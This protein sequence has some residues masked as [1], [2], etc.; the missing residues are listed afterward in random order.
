MLENRRFLTDQTALEKGYAG[1]H[2]RHRRRL[3]MEHGLEG[4]AATK[5]SA[6][7]PTA[8]AKQS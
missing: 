6:E 7:R 4:K 3:R 2:P 1:Y 5:P 8:Q